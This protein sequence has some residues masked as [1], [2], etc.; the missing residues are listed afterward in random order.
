MRCIHCGVPSSYYSSAEHSKRP[1]CLVSTTKRHSFY[2]SIRVWLKTRQNFLS[3]QTKNF[4][5]RIF[6]VARQKI[7]SCFFKCV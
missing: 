7:L 3:F 6:L 2:P 5:R 1:S 4:L